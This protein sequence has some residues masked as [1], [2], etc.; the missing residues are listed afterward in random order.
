MKDRIFRESLE[1]HLMT[2][3]FLQMLKDNF[4]S[5]E[6]LKLAREGFKNYMIEYYNLVLSKTRPHSQGRFDKFRRH[7]VKLASRSSY[8]R[9]VKST[10]EI[11]EVHFKRCP[12]SE[13]M[14][15]YKLKNFS[16]AFCLSDPAF[17]K[18]VLP[19]VKFRRNNLISKGAKFCDNTWLFKRG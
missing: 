9:I 8:L 1:R 15:Q 2:I 6:A 7:Y 19:G 14:K 3:G 12:F 10:P 17:T 13:V 11:L 4:G 5:Q 16:Y 18:A